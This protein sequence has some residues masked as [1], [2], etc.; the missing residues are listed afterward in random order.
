L[1]KRLTLCNDIEIWVIVIPTKAVTPQPK[2][3]LITLDELIDILSDFSEE[4]IGKNNL[5]LVFESRPLTKAQR[6]LLEQFRCATLTPVI[7]P[8]LLIFNK[9]KKR[10]FQTLINFFTGLVGTVV[11][12]I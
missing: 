11:Q 8:L 3:E 7:V 12:L 4:P 1:L 2:P 10:Y 6:Q 5:R 9:R